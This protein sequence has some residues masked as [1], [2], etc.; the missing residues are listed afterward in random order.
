MILLL[1][2]LQRLLYRTNFM[3][4]VQVQMS[5]SRLGFCVLNS[6]SILSKMTRAKSWAIA[7]ILKTNTKI[8]ISY[9][10]NWCFCQFYHSRIEV[11]QIAQLLALVSF[12]SV[13]VTI[14]RENL[15]EFRE[16]FKHKIRPQVQSWSSPPSHKLL[17]ERRTRNA[18]QR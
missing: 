15:R 9:L 14:V 8:A 16:N 17:D 4:W 12:V 18:P 10:A 2:L 6:L 13:S 5:P 11:L 1:Q 3:V 7:I